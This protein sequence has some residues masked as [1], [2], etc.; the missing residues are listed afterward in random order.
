MRACLSN[1][2]GKPIDEVKVC[3]L[4][5]LAELGE[6]GE[7]RFDDPAAMQR[8]SARALAAQ[9]E[10][11]ADI[12]NAADLMIRELDTSAITQMLE[13]LVEVAPDAAQRLASELA[14]RLDL[15]A[16]LRDRAF[17]MIKHVP[18][19]SPKRA[20]RVQAAVLVDA[21]A[22]IVVVASKKLPGER[23]WRRWAV[24]IG[25]TG[26]IEDC[27]HEDAV[28]PS[29]DGADADAAPLIANLVADGYRVASS[30]L[31]HAR[32][33]VAAAARISAAHHG[34]S[35]AYYL[36]RDLLDLG[37]AHLGTR[38]DP[39][40]FALDRATELVTEDP[41]RALSLLARC[42]DTADRA[43]AVAACALAERRHADAVEALTRAIAIEPAWP[44]HHW[45]LACA[46]HALG[47][48]PGCYQAL[49]R[50]LSLSPRAAALRGDPDQ[51]NRI[52]YA[53]AR[54]VELQRAARL[55]GR[56]LRKKRSRV[57][58]A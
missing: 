34:L 18:A 25:P 28:P 49:R 47:D 2:N 40:V 53:E 6:H 55:A 50:F 56:S 1:D 11:A 15:D 31:D 35:S 21:S 42:P 58:D 44:L 32:S 52:A 54:V 41:T 9:L 23:R 5:L 12:A 17:A 13:A 8:R 39:S 48:H 57:S 29:T 38:R 51:P 19:T 33:A 22:R 43:A 7:A 20:S 16:D 14:G 10:S 45:N 26:R 27:L 30:E 46:Y 37:D 24:L 3:A 36:G 4:G